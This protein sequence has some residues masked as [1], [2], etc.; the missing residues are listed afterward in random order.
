[1]GHDNTVYLMNMVVCP[2]I[3]PDV[4]DDQERNRPDTTA[5]AGTPAIKQSHS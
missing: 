3:F 4:L 1:M 2:Y 5:E